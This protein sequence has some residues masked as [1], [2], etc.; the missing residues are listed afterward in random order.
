MGNFREFGIGKG[1]AHDLHKTSGGPKL[2]GLRT[3]YS[4]RF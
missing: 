4:V 3:S 2:N 1:Q